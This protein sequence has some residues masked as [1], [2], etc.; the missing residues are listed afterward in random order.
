MQNYIFIKLIGIA[1]VLLIMTGYSLLWVFPET[2]LNEVIQRTRVALVL[3]VF[4]SVMVLLYLY[5]RR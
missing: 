2:E 1:G 3:N 4:G 5:K